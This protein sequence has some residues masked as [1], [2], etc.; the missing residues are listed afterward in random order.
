[1]ETEHE[2]VFTVGEFLQR[3]RNSSEW[4]RGNL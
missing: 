1:M 3:L 2:D 4:W